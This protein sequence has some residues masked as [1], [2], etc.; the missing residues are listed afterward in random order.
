MIRR[1]LTA[2][3]TCAC[4]IVTQKF[5][6]QKEARGKLKIIAVTFEWIDRGDRLDAS[7]RI[8]EMSVAV[9]QNTLIR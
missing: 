1:N 6:H 7:Y 9:K 3:K 5:T 2:F 4:Q 8:L